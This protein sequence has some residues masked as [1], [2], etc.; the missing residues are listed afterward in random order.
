[1]GP[2]N[3]VMG[4]HPDG[5]RILFRSR[6]QSFNDFIGELFLVDVDGHL[7][8]PLPL[9]RGGFGSYSPDGKLF[10][11]NRIFREFRTWKRYRGGMADDVWLYNFETKKIENL[12]NNAALDTSPCITGTGIYFVSDRDANKKVNL[13]RVD[14]KT[15]ETKQLTQ[16]TDYDI[17][18]PTIGDNAVVFE[19]GGHLYQFDIKTEKLAKIPVQLNEDFSNGRGG[20]GQRQEQH[21]QLRHQPRWQTC[22]VRRSRR[23]FHCSRSERTDQEPDPNPWRA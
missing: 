22:P 5:K 4:W 21:H 3:I 10:A 15:K 20:A 2:N 8:E 19:N 14:P 9:P 13:Y 23:Y 12:T 18:F 11:Y 7:P 16:F 1:M 17:K 6:M